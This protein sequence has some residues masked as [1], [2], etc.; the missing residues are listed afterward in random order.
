MKNKDFSLIS[1][2]N[3]EGFENEALN[4][5]Y[6]PEGEQAAIAT[7]QAIEICRPYGVT[8]IEVFD[9][10]PEGHILFAES[11]KNKKPYDTITYQEVSQRTLEHN[12][13]GEKAQFTLP[14]LQKFLQNAEGQKETL[15]PYH[16]RCGTQGTQ[17]MPPLQTSD[18][19][20][21]IPKGVSPISAGY[22]GFEG[23]TLDTELQQRKVKKLIF[24]GVAT[25][26]CEGDTALNAIDRGYEVYLLSEASRGVNLLTT[27]KK[28]TKLLEAGVKLITLN[29]LSELLSKNFAH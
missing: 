18:F 2:D 22:S 26:Y 16:N 19:D 23:T 5:L 13:I 1:V 3:T 4:E 28:T 20:V 14:E 10:H 11:Y 8:I 24:A 27:Q 21:R 17:P 29:Q 7:K 15:R 9:E 6:V 12:G 25:D